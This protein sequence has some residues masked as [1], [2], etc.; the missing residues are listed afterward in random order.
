M[1]SS[2]FQCLSSAFQCLSLTFP[3]PFLGLPLPFLD[4]SAA[5]RYRE[6]VLYYAAAKAGEGL[7]TEQLD[8][9]MERYVPEPAR[10]S[11]Y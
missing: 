6:A 7:S 11:F 4:L 2:A 10:L 3:L 5:F 8:T 1:S 9:L